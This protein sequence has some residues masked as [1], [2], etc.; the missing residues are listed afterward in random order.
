MNVIKEIQRIND[1]EILQGAS[2]AA[3]WHNRY[4]DSAYI[5]VGGLDFGLTEGDILTVFFT[6]WRSG[7]C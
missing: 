5:F 3:S 4:K 1:K 2:E 7:R 6:I